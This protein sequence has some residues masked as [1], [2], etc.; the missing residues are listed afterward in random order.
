MCHSCLLTTAPLS[1]AKRLPVVRMRRVSADVDKSR[2]TISDNRDSRT[3]MQFRSVMTCVAPK[4]Q[5]DP[6]WFTAST[7]FGAQYLPRL[8]LRWLNLGRGQGETRYLG[9]REVMVPLF[10]VCSKRSTTRP[11]RRRR[12]V[13]RARS[14]VPP[15][16]FHAI[17]SWH[18]V[19]AMTALQTSSQA[20]LGPR[21]AALRRGP[22]T[23]VSHTFPM[24]FA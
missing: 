12:P 19:C 4:D 21:C 5:R 13:A 6:A 15:Q 22:R 10:R 8:Q 23:P 14:S 2:A 9:G 3:Q 20:Y 11:S 7:G 17:P 1:R 24:R 18:Y 16:M